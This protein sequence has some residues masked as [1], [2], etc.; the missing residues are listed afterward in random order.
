MFD[1]AVV[2]PV[3]GFIEETIDPSLDV[4]EEIELSQAEI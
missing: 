1:V 3:V 2:D 4:F